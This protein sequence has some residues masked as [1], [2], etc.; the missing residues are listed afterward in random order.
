ML[1]NRLGQHAIALIN[2]YV[3][4]TYANISEMSK[5]YIPQINLFDGLKNIVNFLKEE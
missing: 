2:E 4:K 1:T 3:D 5:Y